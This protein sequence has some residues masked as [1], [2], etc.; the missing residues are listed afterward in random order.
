VAPR[1]K[2]SRPAQPR[3]ILDAASEVFLRYGFRK[4]SMDD[5][6]RAAGLSRQG[7]Y[8]HFA[9]KELVFKATLRHIVTQTFA[10]VRAAVDAPELGLE[11]RLLGAFEALHGY[12]FATASLAHMNELLETARALGGDLVAEL[13][14]DFVALLTGLLTEAGVATRWAAKGVSAKQ[15]AE[16]LL[17]AGSG[18]KATVAAPAAYRTRMR[19]AIK[20]IT[21]GA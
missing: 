12:G 8:L 4:T 15:L 1:T 19:V 11:E 13:E 20:V 16:L 18:I 17:A 21:A 2:A 7:L 10:A 5:L 6:A 3:A 14:K 9:S